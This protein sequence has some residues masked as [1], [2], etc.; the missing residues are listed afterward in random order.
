[1]EATT[2]RS[3]LGAL[4]VESG[5]GNVNDCHDELFAGAMLGATIT[6]FVIACI[7]GWDH[8]RAKFAWKREQA[9]RKR[10]ALR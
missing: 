7:A 6:L 3:R 10:S 2:G 4:V 8:Y 9:R 1:V 5:Q